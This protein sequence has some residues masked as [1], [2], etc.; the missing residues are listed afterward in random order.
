MSKTLLKSKWQQTYTINGCN[1]LLFPYTN[2]ITITKNFT[3]HFLCTT[4]P[5]HEHPIYEFSTKFHWCILFPSM[6][7]E[8]D[9]FNESPYITPLQRIFHEISN[10]GMV[11]KTCP[12]RWFVDWTMQIRETV[13]YWSRE[14]TENWRVITITDFFAHQFCSN[15][16]SHLVH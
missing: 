9:R 6:A 14:L 3:H 16:Q 2:N 12:V 1:C 7:M 15:H 8:W 13:S 4:K 10:C 11:V 5:H